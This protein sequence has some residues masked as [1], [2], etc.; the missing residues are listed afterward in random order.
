M[1]GLVIRELL[2]QADPAVRPMLDLY[3]RSFSDDE[4]DP[5]DVLMSELDPAVIAARHADRSPHLLV[6]EMGGVVVGLARF[7]VFFGP[8][9][10]HLIHIAI[11]RRHW[12]E[13]LGP[14][15]MD[16]ALRRAGL[17]LQFRGASLTGTAL[18]V[19]RSDLARSEED[20]LERE[21]RIR[22]FE[23]RGAKLVTATYTQ[24]AV[25]PDGEPVPMNLFWLPAAGGLS[26]CEVVVA[27]YREAFGLPEHHPYVRESLAGLA[28]E[29]RLR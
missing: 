13:G 18:E 6:L 28:A 11:E 3:R 16:A 21:R 29:P 4:R 10:A 27:L 2:H 24:P 5:V 19:E 23:R 22:F 9:M 17:D 26:P 1:N 15:L 25:H 7:A 20:R 12:G 8:R 14:M